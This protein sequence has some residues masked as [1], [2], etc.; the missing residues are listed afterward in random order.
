MSM[1]AALSNM[2]GASSLF[3]RDRQR[4][5]LNSSRISTT[6]DRPE[7]E[8]DEADDDDDVEVGLGNTDDNVVEEEH[9][10]PAVASEIP[11]GSA[12]L[13]TARFDFAALEEERELQRRRSS[14]CVMV[15][16]FLLFRLWALALDEGDFGLLLLCLVLTSW[17][18]RWVGMNREREEELDRRIANYAENAA[19]GSNP[20][21]NVN[22]FRVLSFQAQLALAIMESQRQMMQGGYHPEG[23]PANGV[24]DEVRS[25]W[26]RFQYKNLDTG[27][28]EELTSTKAG[29]GS[30]SQKDKK[31]VE[32]DDAPHCSICLSE[33]EEG[34]TVTK[35]PCHHLYHDDCIQSWT[36]AH[37]NCPLCNL[38]LASVNEEAVS[39]SI[40]GSIV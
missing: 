25:K 17:A 31:D 2:A 23:A 8:E 12:A 26:K 14:V 33:Y 4:A 16:V 15:T 27:N 6:A 1:V 32:D 22:D 7:E 21:L 19:E 24:S 3:S 10:R 38:D 18:A 5:R 29:Y 35:L 30:L 11:D 34:E 40:S 9:P 20:E 13:P 39:E 36:E 28:A 37:V